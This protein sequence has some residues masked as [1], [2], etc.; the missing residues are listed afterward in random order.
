M[1]FTLSLLTTLMHDSSRRRFLTTAATLGTGTLLAGQSHSSSAK[2]E[3]S[4]KRIPLIHVTDLYHP[5][6]D[7]DDQLDLATVAALDEYDLKG[8]VLDIT[9]RFLEPAPRGLRSST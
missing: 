9:Q 8:V 1:C 7:P 2:K 6:Q 5:P 4:M 3:P